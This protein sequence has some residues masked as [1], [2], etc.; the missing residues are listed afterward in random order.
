MA[1]VPRQCRGK[2]LPPGLPKILGRTLDPTLLQNQSSQQ[3][4]N[5]NLQSFA[6]KALDQ[7]H[8]ISIHKKAVQLH[9]DS[10]NWDRMFGSDFASEKC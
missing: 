1:L 4:K 5:I 9:K 8:V 2:I 3:V 10:T 6:K 7:D